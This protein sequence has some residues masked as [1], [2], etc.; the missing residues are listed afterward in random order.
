VSTTEPKHV[1][2][3]PVEV[4]LYTPWDAAR[5]LHLPL[6][7]VFTLSGRFRG[8]PEPEWFFFHF[9]RGFPYPLLFDDDLE[10]PPHD[11][12]RGRIS[13]R[14][15]ANLFVRAAIFQVLV[16]WSRVGEK[17][18]DR[19]ENLYHTLWRG[20]ED[21]HREPV[22]FDDSPPDKRVDRLVEPYS[23]RLEEGQ[24]GLLRKWFTLRLERV[25]VNEGRPVRLYPFSRDPAE[26]SPRIIILDPRIRFGR[27]TIADRGVPTDSL[28][29]R[30]Q[31]GD[32]VAELVEDYALTTDEVEEAI[33]FEALP[34]APLFPFYGW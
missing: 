27:P 25:D 6:W 11:E 4:P 2:T 3:N 5:Y 28:F 24:L 31:A 33:R 22:P 20:L 13:F 19:W 14:R 18:R 34:P 15:F 30:Y 7:A 9:R 12:E 17:Q 29:E 1:E 21:T 16:E 32:S 10:L 8:W 23:G 26:N